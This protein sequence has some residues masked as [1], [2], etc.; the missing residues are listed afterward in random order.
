MLALRIARVPRKRQH[1]VMNHSTRRKVGEAHLACRGALT[2]IVRQLR[3]RGK[4]QVYCAN[5]DGILLNVGCGTLIRDGWINVD[6]EPI[7]GRS[8]YLDALD[9]FPLR[10]GSV[11]HIHCEHFLEHLEYHDALR[12]LAESHRVLQ[13][14]GTMRIIVP[15]AE[16]YMQAYVADDREFFDKLVNL[17]NH[18][19]PLKP[20]IRVCNQMFRMWGG[21]KFAWDFEALDIAAR[22]A[23]F[24]KVLLSSH[25]DSGSRYA[26]DGQDWWRPFESLY[27]NLDA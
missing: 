20:K 13:P 17:G 7:E 27:V 2:H 14:N 11:N 10:S 12:F 23:G 5:K 21:H 22:S 4:L 24:S 16:K 3:H 18:E 26:I 1:S 19:E 15:D 25:N 6:Y 9:P 8:F